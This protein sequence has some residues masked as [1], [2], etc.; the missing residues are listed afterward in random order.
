MKKAI[1][2]TE[3]NYPEGDAGAVRQHAFAKLLTDMNY[4]VLVI[5]YGN[6]TDEKICIYDGIKYISFRKNRM[7]KIQ[8]MWNRVTYG[9]KV[10]KYIIDNYT[11]VDLL[12]VVELM[13]SAFKRIAGLKKRYNCVLVHDSVEWY[14]PEEFKY[15][16]LDFAYR[17]KEHTNTKVIDNSWNVIAISTYLEKHFSSR[18]NKVVRIPVIMDVFNI[19][20]RTFVEP[21]NKIVF[22]YAGGPGK[23]D[24]LKEILEGFSL[25]ENDQMQN[26]EL[27]IVGVSRAQL[28]NTCGVAEKTIEILEP[29]LKIHGRVNRRVALNQIKKSDYSLLIRDENLRYAKAGFPTKI[30]ES[31]ACGTPPLCNYSSDLAEYL[32]DGENSVIVHGHTSKDVFKAIVH[33]L[34]YAN[35]QIRE[36]M[37]RN[38]R[39]LAE[40]EFEYSKY[41]SQLTK[42]CQPNEDIK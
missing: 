1:I 9:N 38:A 3:N 34:D 14:S 2:I 11:E 22:S 6:P 4:D 21:S 32:V 20:Y 41:V 24:Y 16:K 40:Q 10:H 30:V 12:F 13:P 28:I 37:R 42:V 25:L 35:P 8:R 19:E 39:K 31:L 26:V 36:S 33:A 15:G 5:G 7:N 17:R 23:K 18:A 27:N 29:C